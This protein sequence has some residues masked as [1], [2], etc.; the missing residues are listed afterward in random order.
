MTSQPTAEKGSLGGARAGRLDASGPGL[1]VRAARGTI[2]NA[3][4]LVSLNALALLKGF[5][6]AAF[7]TRGEYGVW[8]VLS[9]TLITFLALKH[10]GVGE[11]YVQQDDEDQERAFHVAYTMDLVMTTALLVLMLLAVPL[12]ALLYGDPEILAPGLVLAI[13]L[14]FAALQSPVWIFYRRMNFVKQRFLQALEPVTTFAVTVAMALAGFGYWALVAGTVAGSVTMAIGAVIA[15]PYSLRPRWEG[16]A[17]REYVSYSWP[18]LLAAGSGIAISQIILLTG[19]VAVGIAGVG[20][21]MLAYQLTIYASKVD[22]IVTQTIYPAICAVKDRADLLVEAFLKSNKL[23]MLWGMPFGVSCALFAG[24]LIEFGIGQ[25]WRP[26][27]GLIQ[28]FGLTVAVNQ[29]AFN[30]KAFYQARSETRPLAFAAVGALAS[31]CLFTVPL[32]LWLELDGL[33][34]GMVITTATLLVVRVH[35][36]RKLFPKVPLVAHVL[37]AAAPTAAGVGAALALR[38]A[39]GDRTLGLALAEVALFTVVIVATTAFTER[40]LLRE[41]RGYLRTRP[42]PAPA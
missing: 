2:V 42:H 8:G 28:V 27:E 33:M 41:M 10:I 23:A 9:I 40:S 16:G 36:I 20:S 39:S 26:A 18:V 13:A 30:W 11:K 5:I 22:E 32:I 1:R 34:I 6:A 24:D 38:M 21:M 12:L 25:E 19:D 35:Y 7:L 31:T 15:S 4:F 29:I 14:P 37:S 17:M 3:A